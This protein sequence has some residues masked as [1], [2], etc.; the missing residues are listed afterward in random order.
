MDNALERLRVGVAAITE[1]DPT[2]QVREKNYRGE[3]QLPYAP[4]GV[5]SEYMELREQSVANWL[6]TAMNVPVQRMEMESVTDANG[7]V[8]RDAWAYMTAARMHT[9]QRVL[10]TSMMVHAKAALSVTKLPGGGGK[11]SVENVRRLHFAPSPEDPF[12]T[13]YVVKLWTEKSA[14]QAA[15]WTPAGADL[16]GKQYA[17]VYDETS[18]VRFQKD[19]TGP[20]GDWK[21][22][23]ETEHG[24]GRIPFVQIGSNVDAD[25]VPHTALDE[26]VPM[27]NACNTIR[28]NTLLAMQFSAFRQRVAT[29]YDP[30]LRN[31]AGEVI[32]ITDKDGAPIIG[33][34]GEP[35]PALRPG[36][37]VGVDRML[38]FPGKDTKIF[39]LQE[40]NLS[41]YVDVYVRFL[42]DLFTKAQVPPQYA[43][44]KMA[45]LSGDAMAG[46][47]ATLSALVMDLQGE[48]AGGLDEVMQLMDIAHG[49]EPI[50]RE[51]SWADR[52]PKSF[53]QIV[54]GV[55]KLVQ[56]AGFPKRDA[57]D[58]LQ[59][60]TPVKV[61]AW[62]DHAAE[63][64]RE[65]LERDFD[66]ASFAQA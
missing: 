63:E 59:G 12:T 61:D 53:A 41:N 50:A 56:G 46:A 38:V 25:N 20:Y 28:F 17:V 34:N 18:C 40:S 2:W 35:V 10:Y 24:L 55:V 3:Q 54:D 1:A 62:M 60:A 47:D 7:N 65:Q 19:S 52:A 33:P 31:A 11:L 29:G 21:F 58:M 45:N 57:W 32:Y 37:K 27:Q 36:G 5:S 8:D 4:E 44:D 13:E 23:R 22:V 48:A 16:G 42:T 51:I 49:R 39:D 66:A 9:R 6:S 14:P 43:L 15:L 30:L 26:L 64:A